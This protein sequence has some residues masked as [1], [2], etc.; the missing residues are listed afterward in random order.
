MKREIKYRFLFITATSILVFLAVFVYI[1]SLY[2]RQI[3]E[4]TDTLVDVIIMLIIQALFCASCFSFFLVCRKERIRASWLLFPILPLSIILILSRLDYLLREAITRPGY[5][6][7]VS[8]FFSLILVV[9]NYISLRRKLKS[10]KINTANI[11][12]KQQSI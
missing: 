7:I 6:I 10:G 11:R 1:Y 12:E 5:I 9:I 3:T 4:V 8:S 2:E